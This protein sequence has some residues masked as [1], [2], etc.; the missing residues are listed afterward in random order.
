MKEGPRSRGVPVVIST[1]SKPQEVKV[2]VKVDVEVDVEVDAEVDA[3]ATVKAEV[4][5]YRPMGRLGGDT[6]LH[7]GGCRI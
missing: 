4:Y 5:I 6:W 7:V 3:D 2:E 1:L